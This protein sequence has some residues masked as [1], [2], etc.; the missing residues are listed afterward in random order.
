M[1]VLKTRSALRVMLD[2]KERRMKV[3]G[4]SSQGLLALTRGSSYRF[5]R[6][7]GQ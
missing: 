7:L 2:Q 6:T 1:S 3:A 5:V 4:G